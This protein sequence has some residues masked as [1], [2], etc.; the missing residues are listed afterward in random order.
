[1]VQIQ[2]SKQNRFGHLELVFWICL[3]FVIWDLEFN[4]A[5]YWTQARLG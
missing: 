1:M 2:N 4:G 3:G 5:P